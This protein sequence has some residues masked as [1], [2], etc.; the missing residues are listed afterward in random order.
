MIATAL[1][2]V[3]LT[4]ALMTKLADFEGFDKTIFD[5]PGAILGSFYSRIKMARALGV[6]GPQV[7]LHLDTIRT[8]RNTFAHSAF[9][10]DFQH[11]LVAAEIEKLLPD[12]NPDWKP[13][14]TS[15]RRRFLGTVTLLGSALH[16]KAQEHAGERIDLWL[17]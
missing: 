3:S 8:I 6:A 12:N 1:L 9:K 16:E 5:G 4:K 13:E 2:E 15:Q 7:E 10:I 14:F 17:P 11:D